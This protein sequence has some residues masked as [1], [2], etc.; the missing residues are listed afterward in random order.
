MWLK[1][2]GFF[3]MLYFGWLERVFLSDKFGNIIPSSLHMFLMLTQFGLVNKGSIIALVDDCISSFH[4]FLV[5]F[6]FGGR[7]GGIYGKSYF[8]PLG[9]GSKLITV[10][11]S[12]WIWVEFNIS[13][14]KLT[15]SKELTDIPG[16]EILFTLTMSV[17]CLLL[18]LDTSL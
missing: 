17:L 18:L 15:T 10:I 5:T 1:Q 16:G 13:L 8:A 2:I 12:A 14:M 11:L 4:P 7:N 3:P 9:G 6:V